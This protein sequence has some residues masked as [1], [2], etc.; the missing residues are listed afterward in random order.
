MEYFNYFSQYE[1]GIKKKQGINIKTAVLAGG[2]LAAVCVVLYLYYAF[3][4]SRYQLQLDYLE[5]IKANE[6]FM[7][8]YAVA[9]EVSDQIESAA[10]EVTFMG[11]LDEY[12]RTTGVVNPKL[13]TLINSCMTE[14][15]HLRSIEIEKTTIQLEGHVSTIDAMTQMEQ[16]FRESGAFSAVLVSKAENQTENENVGMIEFGCKLELNGGAILDEEINE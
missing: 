2:F 4:G 15:T 7:K 16:K 9:L 12:V 13:L 6:G 8:Q 14:G 5:N 1:K 3:L 10:Q 11:L